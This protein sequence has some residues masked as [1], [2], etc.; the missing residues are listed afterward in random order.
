MFGIQFLYIA[1]KMD[2]FLCSFF[3]FQN[4]QKD[5]REGKFLIVTLISDKTLDSGGDPDE[6]LDNPTKHP[7]KL[8]ND[9]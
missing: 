6:T 4:L 8:H 9:P 3:T 5:I 1:G 2:K 7:D